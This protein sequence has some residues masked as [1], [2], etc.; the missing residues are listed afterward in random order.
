MGYPGI[1]PHLS[2][3]ISVRVFLDEI[4]IEISSL[5]KSDCP[6]SGWVGLTQSGEDLNETERLTLPQGRENFSSQMAFEWGH[7][8]LSDFK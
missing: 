5:S 6:P 2:L 1:L 7:Q 3:G 8:P 4:N